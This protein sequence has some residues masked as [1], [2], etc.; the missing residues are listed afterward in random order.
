M[1]LSFPFPGASDSTSAGITCCF[2][3]LVPADVSSMSCS[4]FFCFGLSVAVNVAM[5]LYSLEWSEFHT[6]LVL[7]GDGDGGG[8]SV[9][10]GCI[11]CVSDG[12]WKKIISEASLKVPSGFRAELSLSK[13]LC[14]A[15]VLCIKCGHPAVIKKNH[16][17]GGSCVFV[18]TM[19]F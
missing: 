2:A 12:E 3:H 13:S 10:A 14:G 16:S 18:R 6:G 11:G 17:V 7:V 5:A 8:L 4:V 9:W 1:T 19:Q 15:I